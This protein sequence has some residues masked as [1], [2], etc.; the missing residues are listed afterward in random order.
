MKLWAAV[1]QALENLG[2][3][4]S[5]KDIFD[6]VLRVRVEHGDTKPISLE[7]VVRKELEYDSSVSSNWRG[8][9]D[10]F[11]SV[12]GLGADLEEDSSKAG[13]AKMPC[14]CYG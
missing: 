14:G 8:T 1:E 7:G 9:R 4:V 11:F 13:P 10:L 5:P 3:K 2:G 12:H 6:E